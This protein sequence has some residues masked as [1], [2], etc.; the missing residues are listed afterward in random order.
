MAQYIQ[1]KNIQSGD[2]S[3]FL[4]RKV[5]LIHTFLQPFTRQRQNLTGPC[6]FESVEMMGVVKGGNEDINNLLKRRPTL[7]GYTVTNT[8]AIFRSYTCKQSKQYEQT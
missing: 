1:Y 3:H 2:P 7:H 6:G 5:R 4:R 8:A